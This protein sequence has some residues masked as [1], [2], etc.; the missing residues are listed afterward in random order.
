MN[1]SRVQLPIVSGSAA[2]H[3]AAV[4]MLI[5]VAGDYSAQ[6]ALP[7]EYESLNR[8]SI[9]SR[10]RIARAAPTTAPS[11]AAS[12]SSRP[13][14]SP[15]LVGTLEQ[16]EGFVAIFEVP[17]QMQFARCRLGDLLPDGSGTVSHITLDY[18]ECVSGNSSTRRIAVGSTVQGDPSAL[19]PTS[20]A[21]G[22]GDASLAGNDGDDL[23]TKMRKRRKREAGE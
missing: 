22:T 2:R 4:L 15:V 17:G 8:K 13:S 6:A 23:L 12:P 21:S 7:K 5:M 3:V 16:E 20:P 1:L 19:P 9:F 11:V 10:E 14:R 18:L